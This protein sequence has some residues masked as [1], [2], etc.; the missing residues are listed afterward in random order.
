[1]ELSSILQYFTKSHHTIQKDDIKKSLDDVMVAINNDVLPS[2]DLV[3]GSISNKTVKNAELL[4]RLAFYSGIKDNKNVEAILENFKETFL[5][6]SNNQKTFDNLVDKYVPSVSTDRATS[7]RTASIVRIIN[8]IG[9]MGLYLVDALYI[10]VYDAKNTEF[11]KIKIKSVEDYVDTFGDLYKAYSNEKVFLQLLKDIPDV[12]DTALDL[13][14]ENTGML[15]ILTEAGKSIILPTASGFIGNPIY[16]IRMWLVDKQVEKYGNLKTKR[17]ALEA[18]LL[19]LKQQEENSSTGELRD[20]IEFYE[21]EIASVEYKM[22][23]IE[24]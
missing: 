24:G 13:T 11:P 20:A 5:M 10:A 7:A 18:R 21:K 19:E 12:S 9:S 6:F 22:K 1:M 3:L 23:E 15:S 17:K 2:I 16:H 8:D 4:K 14:S